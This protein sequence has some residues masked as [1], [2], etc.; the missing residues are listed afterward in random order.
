MNTVLK[1]LDELKGAR[2]FL[3]LLS[4]VLVQCTGGDDYQDY[5]HIVDH[6]YLYDHSGG[7]Y[8]LKCKLGCNSDVPVKGRISKIQLH[9]KSILVELKEAD[10]SFNYVLL[11]ASKE[12]IKCCCNT[13]IYEL[14]DHEV[15]S[16][17]NS[18]DIKRDQM[19]VKF[20]A[21]D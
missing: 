4:L 16:L 2:F 18:V 13:Q 11:V 6:Y 21:P 19:V 3:L 7:L 15:D 8:S 10:L 9:K 5:Q 1:L 14:D 12:E 17:L 20:Q